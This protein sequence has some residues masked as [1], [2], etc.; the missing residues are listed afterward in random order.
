MTMTPFLLT[1]LL[2]AS[3]SGH[4]DENVMLQLY[5]KYDSDSESSI[6]QWLPEVDPEVEQCK[7]NPKN[8]LSMLSQAPAMS[9]DEKRRCEP[10]GLCSAP[11]LRAALGCGWGP[12]WT[13]RL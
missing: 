2:A 11:Q 12:A 4:S 5:S 13:A 7:R 10:T 9:A 1:V 3:V 6:P 8:M